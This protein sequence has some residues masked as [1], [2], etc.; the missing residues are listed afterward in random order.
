MTSLADT[1]PPVLSARERRELVERP[2]PKVTRHQ[3]SY[4]HAGTLLHRGEDNTIEDLKQRLDR[5]GSIVSSW[6]DL[7]LDYTDEELS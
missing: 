7:T 3:C 2:F 1:D 5:N 6:D 4:P